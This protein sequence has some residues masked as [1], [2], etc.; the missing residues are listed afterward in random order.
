MQ[1][2]ISNISQHE[3]KFLFNENVTL[4]KKISLIKSN[5]HNM[6][7]NIQHFVQLNSI[8]Y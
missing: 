8:M 7:Q 3:L 5:V 1:Y 4:E 2:I 6:F